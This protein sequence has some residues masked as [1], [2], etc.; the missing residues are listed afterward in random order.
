MKESF[1][2]ALKNSDLYSYLLEFEET[3]DLSKLEI[4]DVRLKYYKPGVKAYPIKNVEEQYI[5]TIRKNDTS[6]TIFVDT[7]A[8]R[9]VFCSILDMLSNKEVKTDNCDSLGFYDSHMYLSFYLPTR[10]CI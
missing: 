8:Y 4:F 1:H 7:K 2:Q 5:L 9:C 6:R 3:N 10:V